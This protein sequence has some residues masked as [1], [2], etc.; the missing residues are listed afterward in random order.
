MMYE[1]PSMYSN[2]GDII[3]DVFNGV[4]SAANVATLGS[5]GIPKGILAIALQNMIMNASGNLNR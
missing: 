1:N 3:T 4:Y 5:L 2:K